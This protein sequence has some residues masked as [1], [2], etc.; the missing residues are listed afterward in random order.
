[1]SN[2]GFG[3][4]DFVWKKDG[5]SD[6]VQR[7]GFGSVNASILEVTEEGSYT[8]EVKHYRNGDAIKSVTSQPYLVSYYASPLTAT[9]QPITNN[10]LV[11]EKAATGG[12]NKGSQGTVKINY[13]FDTDKPYSSEIKFELIYKE[14]GAVVPASFTKEK[15]GVES[16]VISSA[17]LPAE[18]LYNFR[19]SNIYNGSIFSIE[20]AEFAIDIKG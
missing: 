11:L 6:P 5:E 12:Y 18:G 10:Y 7:D 20:T 16:C 8:V 9:M 3:L 14:T 13:N 4:L 15:E 17:T 19:V 1:M 2:N